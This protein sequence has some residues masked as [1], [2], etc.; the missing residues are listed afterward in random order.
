MYPSETSKHRTLLQSYCTGF[1]CDIGFGGD[2]INE[3]AIR[4]DLPKP[5]ATTGHV[6][7]QLGGDCRDLKWFRDD[8]LDYVFSSHV[9]EDFA[10]EMT[11]PILREWARVL[12]VGGRIVL[13]LPDQQR[14]LRHCEA[15]GQPVNPYH[16]I[17]HFSLQYIRD[18][19]GRIPQ[20]RVV[21]GE[22]IE[23]DYS[24]FAVLEKTA[25][26]GEEES[27]QRLHRTLD[28]TLEHN[29]RL[30]DENME[31]KSKMDRI[32]ANPLLAPL[33][34]LRAALRCTFQS[35]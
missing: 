13:L 27:S 19:I 30:Q 20:L 23:G 16:A 4:V 15:S 28:S 32:R 18:V 25:P 8:V 22:E 9:L 21:A 29:R 31:L 7:V 1:G 35:H 33:L 3:N 6:S 26:F 34:R 12:R 24:F 5:Y 11:E 14:Y 2:P 10:E 17:A